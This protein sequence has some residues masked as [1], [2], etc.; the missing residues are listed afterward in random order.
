[1][2]T[3]S[4]PAHIEKHRR[5]D[6]SS[7]IKIVPDEELLPEEKAYRLFKK[8]FGCIEKFNQEN[9]ENKI[10]VL[11][12]D[13]EFLIFPSEKP[14]KEIGAVLRGYLEDYEKGSKS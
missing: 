9:T 13:L 10:N 4:L 2:T 1:M 6:G 7:Y 11:R 3:A 14:Q 8:A 5:E 12:I